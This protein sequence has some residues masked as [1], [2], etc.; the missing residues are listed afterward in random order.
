MIM[1]STVTYIYKN[2]CPGFWLKQR[3]EST[4]EV[5]RPESDSSLSPACSQ[6]T[7]RLLHIKL[8][9]NNACRFGPQLGFDLMLGPLPVS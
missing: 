2:L 1:V 6:G 8:L 9:F 5:E 7:L 3:S 4:E